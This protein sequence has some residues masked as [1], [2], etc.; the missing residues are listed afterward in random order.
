MSLTAYDPAVSG[1]SSSISSSNPTQGATTNNKQV[2]LSVTTNE[3]AS[4]TAR[5]AQSTT[6]EPMSSHDYL[7][8]E[9]LVTPG[10]GTHNYL[11]TCS[12]THG[13]ERLPFQLSF[14]IDQLPTARIEFE[15]DIE[16]DEPLTAGSYA[17]KLITSEPVQETPELNY[18]LQGSG[19]GTV[20]LIKDNEEGT[21]WRG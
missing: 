5:P 7:T 2:T 11:V 4:C 17:V 15:E 10:E 16:E 19:D 21:E 6:E 14:S 8:H 18:E 12:D 3:V 13:N 20:A 1:S 9:L